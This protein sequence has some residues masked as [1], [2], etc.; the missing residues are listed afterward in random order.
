MA[1]NG[2]EAKFRILTV[3]SLTKNNR[4]IRNNLLICSDE[5][6]ASKN[7]AKTLTSKKQ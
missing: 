4:M 5:L 3:F 1:E 6:I 7:S 2:Q